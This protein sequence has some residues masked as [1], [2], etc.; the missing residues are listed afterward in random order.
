M[1]PVPTL[2]N[3]RAKNA[4]NHYCRGKTEA[5]TSETSPDGHLLAGFEHE[6]T[7]LPID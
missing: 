4:H 1:I 7:W 5:I 3:P 2:L 6:E